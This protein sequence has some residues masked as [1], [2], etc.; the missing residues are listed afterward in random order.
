MLLSR[1]RAR[2]NHRIGAKVHRRKSMLSGEDW[3]RLWS[4]VRKDL[5]C[6]EWTAGKNSWGYGYISIHNRMRRVHRIIWE[7]KNGPVPDGLELDHLCR[8][9]GCCNPEHLEPVTRQ[10]NLRRGNRGGNGYEKKTHCPQGH[11]YTPENTY[12]RDKR[13]GRQCRECLH[14]RAVSAKKREYDHRR[15]LKQK[16]IQG[17]V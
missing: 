14:L 9:R 11:E 6:W 1:R 5:Y 4:K 15:Y 8:N 7:D 10:E 13:S 17:V 3:D 12:I 16:E 2:M